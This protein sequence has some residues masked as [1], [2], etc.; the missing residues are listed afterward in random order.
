MEAIDRVGVLP[1]G[2]LRNV[3]RRRGA[4]GGKDEDGCEGVAH[5]L[6]VAVPAEMRKGPA[7]FGRTLH[8]NQTTNSGRRVAIDAM[9]RV[10]N[11]KLGVAPRE[12]RR[13]AGLIPTAFEIALGVVELAAG[14]LGPRLPAVLVSRL[15]DLVALVGA[16][17]R[18]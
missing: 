4:C 15:I 6:K 13:S 10:A 16:R 3:R 18:T 7:C 11:G 5:D 14:V 8:I 9:P 17:I 12:L 1:I 2:K